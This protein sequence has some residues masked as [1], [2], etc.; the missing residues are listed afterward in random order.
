MPKRWEELTSPEIAALD[1]ARTVVF[2]PIGPLEEHG[3][4]LPTGTDLFE[5][6]EVTRRTAAAVEAERPELTA[7]LLP[8]IPVAVD[9]IEAPGSIQTRPSV[10][11]DLLVDLG[12]SLARQGFVNIVVI[13]HHGSPRNLV[14]L[15]MAARRVSARHGVRMVSPAANLVYRLYFRGELSRLESFLDRPLPAPG[16]AGLKKDIH[17]GAF[18]TSEV[19]AVRPDLVK[20]DY[21]KLAP[22]E[23]ALHDFHPKTLMR[24]PGSQGYMGRPAL[25]SPELGDSYYR[26][27]A[28]EGKRIVLD[29]VDGKPLAGLAH[30]PLVYAPHLWPRFWT[31]LAWGAALMGLAVWAFA[32]AR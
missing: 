32:A 10:I 4:H 27:L 2:V 31:W 16:L 18:E 17:A 14:C 11:Y 3:P 20:A 24:L 26:F 6:L 1:R 22:F 29:V 30:S 8:I 21:T 25:A 15:E 13:N 5:A 12:G 28:D 9:A 23:I 7:V 19:L